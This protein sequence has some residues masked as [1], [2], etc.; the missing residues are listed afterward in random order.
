[1]LLE[2]LIVT[3]LVKKSLR[4]MEPK[5]HYRVRK[6]P[7]T[8]GSCVRFRNKMDFYGEELLSPRS[9]PKMEDR[10]LSA[11]RDCLLN[12]FSA[13]LHIWRPSP[14]SATRGQVTL[15]PIKDVQV[16]LMLYKIY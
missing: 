6:R 16:M 1:V 3:Q 9:A 8:L 4:F 15:Y 5:H 13:V 11:V 7:P 10:S 14:P 12:I 2:K